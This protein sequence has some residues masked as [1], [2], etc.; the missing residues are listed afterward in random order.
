MKKH[1]KQQ[2]EEEVQVI[3][4]DKLKSKKQRFKMK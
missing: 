3:I 4:L 1:I 2:Y